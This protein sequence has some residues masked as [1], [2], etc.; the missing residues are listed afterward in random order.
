MIKYSE[1]AHLIKV[2]EILQIQKFEAVKRA[3]CYLV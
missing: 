3:G 2:N 1:Y